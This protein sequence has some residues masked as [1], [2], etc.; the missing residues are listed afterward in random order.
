MHPINPLN[1]LNLPPQIPLQFLPPADP[2]R[3]ILPLG[4]PGMYVLP[5]CS[6]QLPA[7]LFSLKRGLRFDDLMLAV[8]RGYPAADLPGE[9]GYCEGIGPGQAEGTLDVA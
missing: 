7:D 4:G 2:P 3:Q 6:L 5:D 9:G 1:R 8:G